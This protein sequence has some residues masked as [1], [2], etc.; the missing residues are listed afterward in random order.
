MTIDQFVTILA[1]IRY[2][3]GWRPIFS[4]GPSDTQMVVQ[5]EFARPDAI[6]GLFDVGQGAPFIFDLAMDWTEEALVRTMFA[7]ALRVEEHECREFF[8][9]G[10]QRPFWPHLKLVEDLVTNQGATS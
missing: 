4:H 7:L 5:W 2:K 9:Y 10:D 6:T 3:N 1:N 8:Q